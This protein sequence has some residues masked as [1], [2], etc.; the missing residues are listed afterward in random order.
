MKNKLLFGLTAFAA[1]GILAG[2]SDTFNP[3]SDKQGRIFPT[4]GLDTEVVTSTSGAKQAGS[5]AA[6]AVTPS[7]LALDLTSADGNVQRH[8]DSLDDFPSG[9]DWPIGAYT[10]EASYGS[11]DD[12]GFGKPYY[13]GKTEFSVKDGET[14][15]VSL[16]AQ[17]AN[18]MVTV[19]YTDS[20]KK[21]F[22]TYSLELVT[23]G[24]NHVAYPNDAEGACYV[25]PGAVSLSLKV[26]KFTGA[27]ATLTPRSFTAEPRHHYRLTLDVSAQSGDGVLVL[28]FDEML[29]QEDVIID[30]SDEL[31]NA[32][33]PTLTTK[34]FEN[35]QTVSFIAG[36]APSTPMTLS[37]IAHGGISSVVMKTTSNTLIEQGW[38]VEADLA[39]GDAALAARL[40]AL[41]L[42]S[43]GLAHNPEKMAV[44]NITEV[45]SHLEYIDG[46]DN[47][48]ELIFQARDKYNKVSDEVSVK[49]V[50]ETLEMILSDP[51]AIFDGQTQLAFN[52]SFNGGSTENVKVQIRERSG[53]WADVAATIEPVSRAASTY[54]VVAT[55]PASGDIEISALLANQ[56]SNVLKVTRA[57]AS[58]SLAC[59]DKD[60][61]ARSAKFLIA[62]NPATK[63]GRAKSRAAENIAA[64]LQYSTDGVKYVDVPN[65]SQEGAYRVVSGLN[66]GTTYHFRALVENIPTSAVT[67]TTEAATQLPNSGMDEW[68]Y[69]QVG[70]YQTLWFAGTSSSQWGTMN[71]K[72]T[73]THG[74]GSSIISYG[75]TAYRA[76]SGTM[77]A[78]GNVAKNPSATANS[79]NQHKGTN[80]AMIRTVGW[81]SGNTSFGYIGKCENITAGE[82]FLG[83]T[84]A[85]FNAIRGM[86]FTSRPVSLSFY[87]KYVPFKS[88]NG[89]FGVAE[90]K[91]KDAS[92]AVIA[93]YRKEIMESSDYGLITLPLQY[94]A[95]SAKASTLE[96]NFYSS[97]NSECL[98]FDRNY[99][100]DADSSKYT[101]QEYVGSKLYIDDI[102]LNY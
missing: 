27:E 25:K 35:G 44:I 85:Q 22:E 102:T 66:A 24:D 56:R 68:S 81:G 12:E 95:S 2:C 69:N 34:G 10:M 17:L 55:V 37:L 64:T 89:D 32:P 9:E 88:G 97:G 70:D 58:Y 46:I 8:W 98:K 84:D 63:N 30:L 57:Q 21:F 33:A 65:V 93:E 59:D 54:R 36:A 52:M 100:S 76:T 87:A 11:V 39:A 74:K 26:K 14:T 77:P 43:V 5:R 83:H 62:E 53:K 4:V 61:F 90:I 16:T 82:L 31:I 92:G 15:P 41:G 6:Q 78:N 40:K 7:Q 50:L 91:V 29:V 75:G 47:T 49:F 3:G 18:S 96:V 94:A 72:T 19:A 20:F 48:T 60:V 1:A 13:Y 71:P 101:N 79:G 51:Q 42:S 99:L 28:K 73:S 23:T 38:P 67:I 80:A 45:M 86:T